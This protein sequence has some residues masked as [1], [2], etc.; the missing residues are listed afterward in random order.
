MFGI[1]WGVISFLLLSALGEG[2]ARGN[3]KVLAELG[4][5]IVIIRNGRTSM[6]AGGARA[7]RVVRLTIDDLRALQAESKLLA[8]HQP[9]AHPGRA[10]GEE[11]LQL[12]LASR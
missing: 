10:P 2:F 5:N 3:Q 12:Q 11:R 1:V 4:K 7:G 8:V 9:G 6:Q